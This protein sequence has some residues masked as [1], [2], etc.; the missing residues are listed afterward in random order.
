MSY[1]GIFGDY[2][3]ERRYVQDDRNAQYCPGIRSEIPTPETGYFLNKYPII[4]KYKY[5]ILFQKRII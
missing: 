5:N 2:S 4:I 3:E 1:Q